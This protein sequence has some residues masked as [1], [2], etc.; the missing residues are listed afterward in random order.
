M[1]LPA[2]PR[3]LPAL[4]RISTLAG[5]RD[6]PRQILHAIL[7]IVIDALGAVSGDISLLN[8]DTGKLEIEIADKGDGTPNESLSLRLGQGITG[9]VAFHGRPQLVMDVER[10]PRYVR[11]RE[12]V[13]TEM[14]TPMIGA[15]SQVMGVIN[16]DGDRVGGFNDMDLEL[17]LALTA[18]ATTVMERH[19]ELLNLR[20]KE[21][22]L[23]TLISIGQTLVSKFEPQELFESMTRDAR[24]ITNSRACALYLHDAEAQTARLVAFDGPES[25]QLPHEELPLD[26]CLVS[27][28]IHTKR[29]VEFSD[30]QSPEFVDVIDLPREPNLR[31]MLATPMAIE[32]EIIGVLVVFTS[33]VHRFNND[34]KR[35]ARALTSLGAV[36][37]Q[38][39]R[40]YARVFQSEATLRKNEQLTTLGLL[41]AEI[42]H[43]IRNPLTVLK[44]LFSTLRLDYPEG[45]PR[46]TDVRVITEKLDQLEAIVSRVLNFAKAP[47]SL[48]SRWNVS[49][50]IEDT[51]VLIRLKLTQGKIQLNYDAPEQSL[52]VDVHKGQLQQVLLNLL[53]N[54]TQVM[55]D[56]GRITL[57]VTAEHPPEG[58]RLVRI[59]VSDTGPG[60]PAEM[61]DR[62]FDSFLSGRPDGTGLGLAI[63]KRILASHHGDIDLRASGPEGTTMSI[64]LPLA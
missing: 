6:E 56:G 20:G 29:S 27:S 48:H 55:P 49:D 33:V 17:M 35:L 26:T 2:D 28:A 24:T 47:S 9:W 40:L 36:A 63:A 4:Y 30:I 37:L 53:I 59:D 25:T 39:S 38:N 22:Q 50:I 1:E 58:D 45:D 60:I 43:E 18:E 61:R 46:K 16:V 64:I 23:S 3:T 5:R 12:N 42:A 62:I 52:I 14:V 54:A 8:P 51:L 34:E 7:K 44:L 32:Q 10:D 21:R 15:N 11:V 31:S 57:S 41:A 19:W 13:R